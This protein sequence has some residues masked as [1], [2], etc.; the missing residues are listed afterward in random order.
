L[1]VP[2]ES[3]VTDAGDAM[4]GTFLMDE[5]I[6]CVESFLKALALAPAAS[7]V[8]SRPSTY[9]NA[10]FGV[11]KTA[12]IV[13]TGTEPPRGAVTQKLDSFFGRGLGKAFLTCQGNGVGVVL[14]TEATGHG[15]GLAGRLCRALGAW[16]LAN[17][18]VVAVGEPGCTPGPLQHHVISI[19]EN[20]SELKHSLKVQAAEHFAGAFR[21]RRCHQE[22]DQ[23]LLKREWEKLQ[24]EIEMRLLDGDG[25]DDD[26]ADV[27]HSSSSV[28]VWQAVRNLIGRSP[29]PVPHYAID[30]KLIDWSAVLKAKTVHINRKLKKR[31]LTLVNSAS[32]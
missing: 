9:K 5:L 13:L 32:W 8:L 6:H 29:I 17:L 23:A 11:A 10:A 2:L 25:G 3:S 7:S 4:L 20:D 26:N 31:T 12:I 24:A 1:S 16:Q 18:R 28:T 14:F 19:T 27:L 22:S 21:R 30:Q 15:P